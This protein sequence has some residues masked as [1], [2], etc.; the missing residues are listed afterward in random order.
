MKRLR[1]SCARNGGELK[2]AT[3]WRLAKKAF[4]TTADYD[5]AISARLEQE[6]AAGELPEDLALRAPKVMDL[7]YGENRTSRRRSTVERGRELPA[8]S[9]CRARSCLTTT[10]WIW[11]R[12]GS[13][14]SEFADPAVAIIKHTNPCGCAEQATLVEA[15]RKA[16]ECDPVSAYGGVVGINR[17]VDVETAREIA[18]LFVEA[19]AAPD[20]EPEALA[21]LAA[22]KNLRLMKIAPGLDRFVVKSITGGF[23]VQRADRVTMDRAA[24]VVK[25]KRAPTEEECAR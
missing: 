4:R 23:L 20:Y 17:I 19:V 24:A 12:R 1:P 21:V 10:W 3:H 9:S 14:R 5:A 16:L 15:W 25:T 2:P 7:R 8:R 22:K 13:W 6:D 18:K 11:M